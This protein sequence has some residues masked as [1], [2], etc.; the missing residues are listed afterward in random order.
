MPPPDSRHQ[1]DIHALR[2]FPKRGHVSQDQDQD[3][4]AKRSIAKRCRQHVLI[5]YSPLF[6]KKEMH[7]KISNSDESTRED[8]QPN[9]IIPE[10]THV[11]AESAEDGSTRHFDV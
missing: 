7:R 10:S 2:T 11:E 6:Y 1:L 9:H 3:P 5:S 4:D 8:R